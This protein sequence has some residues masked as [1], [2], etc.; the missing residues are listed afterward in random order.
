MTENA[1]NN[2][3]QRPAGQRPDTLAGF[4]A[5][6][7]DMEDEISNSVYKDYMDPDNWPAG[8][9]LNVFQEIRKRLTTLIEDTRRHRKI[10]SG[11]IKN[12]GKDKK[13]G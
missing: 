13:P 3:T 6:A 5:S 1:A 9:D 11:L 12:H 8:M 7:L 2:D 4:L 10:I